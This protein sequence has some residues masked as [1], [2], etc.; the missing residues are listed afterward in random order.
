M[1]AESVKETL[2]ELLGKQVAEAFFVFVKAHRGLRDTEMYECFEETSSALH[3][4]FG[5][6]D[7]VIGR[8]IIRKFCSKLD[9]GDL[10]LSDRSLNE[11]VRLVN[12][13]LQRRWV[14]NPQQ[15][16]SSSEMVLR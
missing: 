13:A 4:A 7:R 10:E 15:T 9:M 6:A 3:A 1:F 11:N 8:R 16:S 5:S 2:S 12:A 14:K